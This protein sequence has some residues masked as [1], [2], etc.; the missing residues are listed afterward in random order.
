LELDFDLKTEKKSAKSSRPGIHQSRIAQAAAKKHTADQVTIM[1]SWAHCYNRTQFNKMFTMSA[2]NHM[3]VSGLY[4][5]RLID[6][7]ALHEF[8]R[9]NF[10]IADLF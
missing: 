5:S 7:M 3:F 10:R 2:N 6:A 9:T 1:I 8:S 4:M